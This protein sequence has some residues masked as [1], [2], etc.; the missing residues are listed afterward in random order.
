[1]DFFGQTRHAGK[2]GKPTLGPAIITLPITPRIYNQAA[3]FENPQDRNYQFQD[4]VH[5]NGSIVN[6]VVC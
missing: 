2:W 5:L 6:E 3:P 1:M 4:Y